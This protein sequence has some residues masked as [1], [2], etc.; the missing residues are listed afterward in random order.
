MDSTM[1]SNIR[2]KFYVNLKEDGTHCVQNAVM[3][4]LGQYHEH[5]PEDFKKWREGIDTED[6]IYLKETHHD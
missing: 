1:M 5:T 2:M 4:K 6:I 3:G